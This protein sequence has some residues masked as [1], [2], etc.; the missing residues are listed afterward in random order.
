MPDNVTFSCGQRSLSFLGA[1]R[2]SESSGKTDVSGRQILR[3]CDETFPT[4][5]SFPVGLWLSHGRGGFSVLRGVQTRPE[6]PLG[7][8]VVED[9]KYQRGTCK[10]RLLRSFLTAGN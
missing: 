4:S 9:I 5:Q 8:D 7:G 3:P 2:C 1:G 6:W 10:K